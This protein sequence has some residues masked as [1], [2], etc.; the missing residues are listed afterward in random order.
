[1]IE[2]LRFVRQFA[3]TLFGLGLLGLVALSL[4]TFSKWSLLAVTAAACFA[5]RAYQERR[6]KPARA[7]RSNDDVVVVYERSNLS[8]QYQRGLSPQF[9]AYM[10]ATTALLQE[11][12]LWLE[13]R[14]WIASMSISSGTAG[15]G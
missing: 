15:G 9:V 5:M 3:L 14:W 8:S 11:K 12:E 7:S 4:P 13:K 6:N 10:Q 2:Y 1:M